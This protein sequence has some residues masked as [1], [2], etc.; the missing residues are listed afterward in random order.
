MERHLCFIVTVPGVLLNLV[1]I[2]I[3]VLKV[4]KPYKW[5]LANLAANDLIFVAVSMVGQPV[6]MFRLLRSPDLPP[7]ND[8]VR[9]SLA[10][11]LLS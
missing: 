11:S 9:N 10:N 1:V 4:D 2:C 7:E 6:V 5:F 3:S 8:Y